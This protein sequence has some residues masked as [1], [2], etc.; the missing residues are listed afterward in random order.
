MCGWLLK[1]HLHFY[2]HLQKNM[3]LSS[4]TVM[5]IRIHSYRQNM[6]LTIKCLTLF[7]SIQIINIKLNK[8]TQFSLYVSWT[9]FGLYGTTKSC[10]QGQHHEY[11]ALWSCCY[12]HSYRLTNQQGRKELFSLLHHLFHNIMRNLNCTLDGNICANGAHYV[13]KFILL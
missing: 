11:K 4:L 7:C 5:L 10:E 13:R 12:K 3:F 9:K 6:M 2:I 8:N 1:I